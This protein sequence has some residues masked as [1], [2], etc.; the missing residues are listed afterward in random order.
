MQK[1]AIVDFGISVTSIERLYSE[2]PWHNVII[3][4]EYDII[5][6]Q[7]PYYVS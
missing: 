4:N 1:L 2:G 3:I 6:E 7:H 5:L